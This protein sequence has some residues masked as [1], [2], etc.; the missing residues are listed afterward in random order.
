MNVTNEYRYFDVFES[1][2]NIVENA[3]KRN[4]SNEL[5]E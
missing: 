2:D 5:I 4:K 1:I 3:V